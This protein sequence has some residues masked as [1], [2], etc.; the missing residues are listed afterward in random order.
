M[1]IKKDMVRL[2]NKLGQR[3]GNYD[4]FF[5]FVELAALS[6]ANLQEPVKSTFNKRESQ[7]KEIVKRYSKEEIN[8]FAE[9]LAMLTNSLHAYP[10]DIL[11]TL[12][13]ELNLQNLWKA[14][15]FSPMNICTMM[16]EMMMGNAKAVLEEK[17]HISI[18]EPACGSGAMLIGAV[19]SLLRQDVEYQTTVYMEATDIDIRCVY[20][21][22]VQLSLL[23]VA[24]R[25]IHGN[26][27][28]METFSVWKTPML[29]MIQN[30]IK[31]QAG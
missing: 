22:Y 31:E 11:G 26:T 15:Y 13:H 29:M 9:L 23:D 25:V 19:R 6:L 4:V 24:A 8:V 16:A 20:M 5:H 7:Y 10:D 17:G 21:T 30:K 14:Q 2:I 18:C 27:L 3:Y 1:D 28:T 12:F